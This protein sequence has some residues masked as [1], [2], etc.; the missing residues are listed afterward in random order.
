[1]TPFWKGAI[2]GIA[3]YWAFQHFSGMG[4]SGK[5]ARQSGG[6]GSGPVAGG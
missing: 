6:A 5:G 4:T 2:V 1:M 3:A